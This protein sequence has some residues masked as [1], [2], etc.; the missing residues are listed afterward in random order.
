MSLTIKSK[1]FSTTSLIM[2]VFFCVYSAVVSTVLLLQYEIPLP[3][4]MLGSFYSCLIMKDIGEW[5]PQSVEIIEYF[6][7][8]LFTFYVYAKI[9]FVAALGF[10]THQKILTGFKMLLCTIIGVDI[11]AWAYTATYRSEFLTWAFIG[12][13]FRALIILMH[14]LSVHYS[15][16]LYSI[17][18]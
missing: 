3:Y 12:I 4:Q 8:G 6:W 10:V 17:T 2:T 9:I 15:K 14:L 5:I 13:V 16:K 18:N 7:I 11:P 1:I